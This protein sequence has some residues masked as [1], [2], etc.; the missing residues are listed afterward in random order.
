ML[1]KLNIVNG[2]IQDK[3]IDGIP[4]YQMIVKPRGKNNVRTMIKRTGYLGTT[5]HDTANT[6]PTAHAKNHANYLQNL[7][8]ADNTYLSVHLFVDSDCIVQTLPLH[9]VSYHAG[10]G[11]GN[12]NYKTISIEMCENAERATVE[13]NAKKLNAA[14]LLTYGGNLYK[15]QD[16]NGKNCPHV[17]LGRNGWPSF[18]ADIKKLIENAGKKD[19]SSTAPEGVLYRVQVGA[20][21]VR[22]NADEL[23]EKLNKAGFKTYMVKKDGLYKVQCGAYSVK[24]NAVAQA[25]KLEAKGFNTYITT[26]AGD[27]VTSNPKPAPKVEFKEGDWVGVKVGAKD[28][29]GTPAGGVVRGKIYYTIDELRGDRAVLDIPGICTPFHTKDLF[30]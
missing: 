2:I 26:Y 21:K 23:E 20:F 13:K 24:S 30:K 3:F 28:Y 10:D 25:K 4:V 8:N 18:T 17:I 29:N 1:K 16:W 15:H 27:P 22:A 5:N 12:G 19:S 14:L 11:K 9:E 6:A 7:E